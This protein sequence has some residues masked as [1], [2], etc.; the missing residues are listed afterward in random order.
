M[1]TESWDQGGGRLWR[2]GGVQKE[3]VPGSLVVAAVVVS[4]VENDLSRVLDYRR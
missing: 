2:S 1:W 3:I 4:P